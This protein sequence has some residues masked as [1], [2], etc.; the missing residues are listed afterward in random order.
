MYKIFLIWLLER[1]LR[2]SLTE[3]RPKNMYTESR[4]QSIVPTHA[5]FESVSEFCPPLPH[6]PPTRYAVSRYP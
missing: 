2:L 6:M 4:C 5:V 3:A 1:E